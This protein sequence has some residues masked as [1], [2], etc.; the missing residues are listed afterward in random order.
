MTKYST[1]S[2][3]TETSDDRY[4]KVVKISVTDWLMDALN[5]IIQKSGIDAR[6]AIR[7][8]LEYAVIEWHREFEQKN[9][10]F[11]IPGER[12]WKSDFRCRMCKSANKFLF[13]KIE[14]SDEATTILCLNCE[15]NAPEEEFTRL[16][17]ASDI[18]EMEPYTL[19]KEGKKLRHRHEGKF[20]TPMR[21]R[22]TECSELDLILPNPE[23]IEA[24]I[25]SRCGNKGDVLT[26]VNGP[27]AKS[28]EKYPPGKYHT[29]PEPE[30][31]GRGVSRGRYDDLEKTYKDSHER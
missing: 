23:R 18:Q 9:Q 10:G 25:C 24:L 5:Q 8:P 29:E 12:V 28:F 13:R 31:I 17:R 27:V 1:D 19:E 11:E 22:C 3:D 2:E 26:Q 15:Y 14:S 20:R 7:K 6:D 16:S 4:S 30:N 21:F